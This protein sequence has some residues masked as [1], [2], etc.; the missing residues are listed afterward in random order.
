[1]NTSKVDG[2]EFLVSMTVRHSSEG[3][4]DAVYSPDDDGWYLEQ[5][6]MRRSRTRVSKQ[7][8]QDRQSAERA[9]ERGAVK[10]ERWH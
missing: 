8:W 2:E 7:V 5:W 10:W 3:C 4:V 6:D 1:M 9:L